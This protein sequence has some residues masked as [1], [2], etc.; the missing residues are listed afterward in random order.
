MSFLSLAQNAL[1]AS[2]GGFRP[3][4]RGFA[5]GTQDDDV[6]T[7]AQVNAV[8]ATVPFSASVSLELILDGSVE[9]MSNMLDVVEEFAVGVFSDP[10]NLSGFT[11]YI[12]TQRGSYWGDI[13]V[14]VN[15]SEI[16]DVTIIK[17]TIDQTECNSL[18]LTT[19]N[20]TPLADS[21]ITIEVVISGG[22]HSITRT[23]TV[24]VVAD[25]E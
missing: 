3:I 10:V 14:A 1:I 9:G 12:D 5:P 8:R 25:P 17:P 23:L 7:V 19:L 21:E 13:T 6:A 2:V 11:L 20:D 22:G 16:L 4:L 18:V 15:A 24:N